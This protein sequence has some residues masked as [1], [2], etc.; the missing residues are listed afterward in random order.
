MRG[1]VPW[2]AAIL[3]G[4]VVAALLWA[5]D[6]DETSRIA[7]RRTAPAVP[8]PSAPEGKR[9]RLPREPASVPELRRRLATLSGI[10]LVR[11]STAIG[12]LEAGLLL[13]E[14]YGRWAGEDRR[15]DDRRVIL[16]AIA[17]HKKRAVGLLLAA[18]AG[19]PTNPEEDPLWETAVRK[20]SGRWR[21][22][23]TLA[24]GR[25]LL[26]MVRS[27]KVR[28][29]L[30]ASLVESVTAPAGRWSE[31]DRLT[32]A[33]DL[34]DTY[35]Q[36]KKG[37]FRRQIESALEE[38]AAEAAA[39]LL[40]AGPSAVYGPEPSSPGAVLLTEV[41]QAAQELVE[42]ARRPDVSFEAFAEAVS[43]LRLLDPGQL[44]H[45]VDAPIVD[46]DPRAQKLLEEALPDPAR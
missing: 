12:T 19:D 46:T 10:E 34:V 20:L 23:E 11:A 8:D 45:L 43:T 24:Q 35:F 40:T 7:G 28:R 5:L 33:G 6:F 4:G 21:D 2:L 26:L 30:A 38:L 16:E 32:L 25:D 9:P 1:R 17:S 41:Q 15:V 31:E 22:P 37:A 44:R 18:V 29:L 14:A 27:E 39:A 13:V 3:A 36:L 42:T